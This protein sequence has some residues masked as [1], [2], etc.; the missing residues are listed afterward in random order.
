MLFK[1]II[2]YFDK[3]KVNEQFL[4]LYCMSILVMLVNSGPPF[5]P[6]QAGV[7][8]GNASQKKAMKRSKNNKNNNEQQLRRQYCRLTGKQSEAKETSKNGPR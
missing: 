7:G 2:E 1:D 4:S 5:G 3:G 8:Y 6:F